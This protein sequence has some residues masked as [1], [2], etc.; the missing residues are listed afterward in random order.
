[1]ALISFD[2]GPGRITAV[3]GSVSGTGIEVTASETAPVKRGLVSESSIRDQEE[4]AAVLLQLLGRNKAFSAKQA[5]VTINPGNA[6]VREFTIPSGSVRQLDA[7]VRS[8]MLNYNAAA[9]TD[10]IEYKVLETITGQNGAKSARIRA[11]SISRAVVDGYASLLQRAKLRPAAMDLYPNAVEKL[12]VRRP[13]LNGDD[14]TEKSCLLLDFGYQ[15][16]MAH[17]VYDYTV[18]ASR[19]IP[20][21]L[22][23]LEPA[24]QSSRFAA[25][26]AD[27]MPTDF[28]QLLDFRK[29]GAAELRL[30][31]FAE[32]VLL[33]C[34]NE[35]QKLLMFSTSRMPRSALTSVYLTGE[36]SLLPGIDGYFASE[37]SLPVTHLSGIQGVRY[38]AKASE[39]D[40]P[41]L[42][43]AVG[44]LIRLKG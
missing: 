36:G 7:M 6:L 12:L 17:V 1:M 41:Y 39:N 34:C 19:F 37:L 28:G 14:L 43:N 21:G 11:F 2:I 16:V 42:L 40:T 33:Q 23:D 18:Y 20:I 27:D 26:A 22:N 24:V 15:G 29:D 4:C 31:R 38:S 10:V 35:I 44:A 30:T 9:A 8:E 25:E 5:V 32:E 3:Q 13:Q